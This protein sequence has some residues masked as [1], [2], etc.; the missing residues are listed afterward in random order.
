M[1][2]KEIIESH[3]Q[4]RLLEILAENDKFNQIIKEQNRLISYVQLLANF[5]NKKISD[6]NEKYIAIELLKP[7]GDDIN[8]LKDKLINID[9]IDFN[10]FVLNKNITEK[11][12]DCFRLEDIK[13]IYF[14]NAN[15]TFLNDVDY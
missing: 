14:R 10:G 7:F 15:S 4:S 1:I 8:Y 13:S 11:Q 12:L 2:S 6:E 9:I 5:I 3:F